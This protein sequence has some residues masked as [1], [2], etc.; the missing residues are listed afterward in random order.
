MLLFVRGEQFARLWALGVTTLTALATVPLLVGFDPSTARYQFA[1][2]HA[3][4]PRFQIQYVL[5][6]DG[7][8]ILLVALTIVFLLATATLWPFSAYG[9]TA[10]TITVLVALLVCLIPTTIRGSTSSTGSRPSCS[11]C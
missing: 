1:E 3:W 11:A 2:L 6:V 8:S 10:V 4:I 9:G 5:G 7:I